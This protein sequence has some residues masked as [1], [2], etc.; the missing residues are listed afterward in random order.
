MLGTS[1]HLQA[2]QKSVFTFSP[3]QSPPSKPQSNELEAYCVIKDHELL[4]TN[5]KQKNT[6]FIVIFIIAVTITKVKRCSASGRRRSMNGECGKCWVFAV[7]LKFYLNILIVFR[8]RLNYLLTIDTLYRRQLELGHH[9]S[10][11]FVY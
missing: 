9:N 8:Q 10:H 3:Q 1:R 5:N 2:E 11:L 4:S 7:N 6:T